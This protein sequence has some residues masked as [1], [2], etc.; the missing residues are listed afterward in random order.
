MYL[1]VLYLFPFHCVSEE[2]C[3]NLRVTSELCRGKN[4][5]PMTTT[6]LYYL[7]FIWRFGQIFSNHSLP[8]WTRVK[9]TRRR[10]RNR[11]QPLPPM[12]QD[13]YCI[14]YI[15]LDDALLVY[16][17]VIWCIRTVL[18]DDGQTDECTCHVFVWIIKIIILILI[19]L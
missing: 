15:I 18:V 3:Y 9:C 2:Q 10:H 11:Q 4:R 5:P 8:H 13:Y 17:G 19:V 1:G 7:M 14:I 12:H 16:Y 6:R